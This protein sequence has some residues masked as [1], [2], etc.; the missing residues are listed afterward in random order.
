M[1]G[2]RCQVSNV[3]C[4]VSCVRCQVAGVICHYI[5]ECKKNKKKTREK[6]GQSGEAG[7]CKVCYQQ[8]NPNWFN[9][10]PLVYLFFVCNF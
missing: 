8:A 3:R 4:Q 1:S 7:C 6:N 10:L 5:F 9:V 2:V